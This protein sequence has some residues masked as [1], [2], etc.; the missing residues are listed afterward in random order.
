MF[1][2]N[3]LGMNDTAFSGIVMG[4]SIILVLDAFPGAVRGGGNRRLSLAPADDLNV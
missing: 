1:R 4:Y 2:Q 3:D